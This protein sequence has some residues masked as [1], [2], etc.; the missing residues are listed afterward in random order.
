MGTTTAR[1]TRTSDRMSSPLSRGAAVSALALAALAAL[2]A[3]AQERLE[4][5]GIALY[6]GLVPEAI[7]SQQHAISELHGGRPPGGGKVNHLVLALFDAK[8]GQRIEG[9]VVR[10]QLS[11]PGVVDGAPR[12]VPPMPINGVNS[13]GQLFGMVHDG[14]YRFRISV[15]VPGRLQETE[16]T[17][18]A[19]PQLGR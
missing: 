14:P 7:V 8:T 12:Y 10:A 4:R 15:Q 6:W 1:C 11:E 13:Y 16:F 5:D 17:I 18:Q 19:A 3:Q 2:S 9:A